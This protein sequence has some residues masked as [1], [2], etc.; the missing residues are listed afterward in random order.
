[1]NPAL[2]GKKRSGGESLPQTGPKRV[3]KAE[4][5]F[6]H[7]RTLFCR[8][9]K[10]HRSGLQMKAALVLTV[11]VVA[12][13]S[14]GGW[15]YYQA[16]A[17]MMIEKD[18]NHALRV[19]KTVSLAA[20]RD[21]RN[22]QYEALDDLVNDLVHSRDRSVM[23][24][25]IVTPERESA[26]GGTMQSGRIVA[27]ACRSDQPAS[28]WHNRTA[29][30]STAVVLRRHGKN[31]IIVG[32]PIVSRD[33][34]YWQ[35]RHTGAVRIVLDTGD[36]TEALRVARQ[37][38]TMVVGLII[39]CAVPLGYGLVW[40]V[41]VRPIRKLV[42]VTRRLGSGDW[43]ARSGICTKDE[44]GELASAFDEM[45]DEVASMRLE[46]IH[47][48]EQLECQV[49]ERT[50]EL[51]R[52]NSR[53]R[54]EMREK[55]DFLRAVSHDLNAP[56]RNIAGMATM[57]MVKHGEDLPE[58]A[59]ARLQRIQSNVEVQTSMLSDLLDLSRIQS[60]PEAR[61]QT[62]IG[63]L[64]T[65]LASS[66]E[67]ELTNHAIQLDIAPSMP[68]LWVEPNRIRE[69]FQNLLDNAIKYMNRSEGGRIEVGYRLDG[70]EHIFR[71]SDNGPGIPEEQRERVFGVFR[72]GSAGATGPA[73]RGVG[74]AVVRN[75]AAKYGGR[76][77]VESE[78]GK[79]AT[80]L[81]T[82]STT[83]CCESSA[84]D[85]EVLYEPA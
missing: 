69:V 72:R 48:N 9:R 74:L 53:L 73:G 66:F 56:L 14:A 17:A 75:I 28:V 79:G 24:V 77:W 26:D 40:L 78:P 80:F 70:S 38:T 45:A 10:D 29:M 46:L 21:L 82:L 39:V 52:T 27:F 30:P 6:L 62:D 12:V 20:E 44:T 71:V 42:G 1:M 47:H 8:S 81:F 60:R 85:P 16:V 7:P 34:V 36:T 67:Y 33:Q 54:E 43:D 65:S 3:E 68:T 19:A 5:V 59:L 25:A 4:D 57:I 58:E 35:E 76:A 2:R 41:M 15:F 37:N 63:K 22:K 55:E 32:R 31:H 84:T 64:L 50:D 11:V 18:R 49:A 61:C 13:A 51:R 23:Y 83:E